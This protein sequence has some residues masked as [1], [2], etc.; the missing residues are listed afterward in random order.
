MTNI[1]SI[2]EKLL[3]AV[4]MQEETLLFE[5]MLAEIHLEELQK[6]LSSDEAKKVFWINCYNAFYQLLAKKEQLNRNRIFK[7][8]II[9]IANL[10]LSLDDIE[11]GI[12]RKYRWKLSFGYLPNIFATKVIKSLAVKKLDYRI[13]FALNCGAKSCP[14]IAFYTLENLDKQLNDAMYSFLFSETIIDEKNKKIIT[15]RLLHW[16]QGDFGG[17]LA[18]KSIMQNILKI[19]LEK[20]KLSFTEYDYNTKL[21]NFTMD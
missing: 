6:Q 20:Y 5:K 13:H 3:L 21:K 4:K 8:K 11:H 14:P 9:S 18:I 16:Y 7:T 12:L 2:S 1:L 19:K 10:K 15:S 17:K